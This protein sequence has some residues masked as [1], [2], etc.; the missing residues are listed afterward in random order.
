MTTVTIPREFSKNTEL[1]AV[2]RFVYED[3]AQAL[4]KIK[5]AKTFRPTAKDK[6]ELARARANYRRGNFVFLKDL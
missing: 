3:Y 4:Q 5:N 2:P 6:R 1:F